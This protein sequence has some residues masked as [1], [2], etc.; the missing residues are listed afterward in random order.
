MYQW[1]AIR[2][3]KIR[4]IPNCGSTSAGSVALGVTTDVE[5]HN[6]INVPTQQQVL[7]FNPALLSP[8]WGGSMMEMKFRG[9]KLFECYGSSTS[10]TLNLEVQAALVMAGVGPVVATVTGQ[11]WLDYVID[12]YQQVPLLS[13]VDLFRTGKACSRCH[14]HV[15]QAP[16]RKIVM[17][18]ETKTDQD[19][20]YVVLRATEP[21]TGVYQGLPTYQG[22]EPSPLRRDESKAHS[23]ARSVSSKG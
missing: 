17:R 9:T 8:V 2:D 15:L 3:L 14:Q 19:R 18:Q 16:Q 23:T 11:I 4:Y 1:Y 10:E 21:L 7:E 6:D 13:A 20:D 5:I 12:F 22:L